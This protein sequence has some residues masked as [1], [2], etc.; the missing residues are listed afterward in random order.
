MNPAAL[1]PGLGINLFECGPESHGA[2]SNGQLWRSHTALLEF[3]QDFSP[4]LGGFPDTVLN[5][6]K[7]FLTTFV[8]SYD[9]QGTQFVLF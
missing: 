7:L 5:G 2:I 1:A 3:K 8:D 6:Q 4:A 9:D